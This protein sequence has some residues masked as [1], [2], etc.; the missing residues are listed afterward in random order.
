[1]AAAFARRGLHE[2]DRRTSGDWSALLLEAAGRR[3]ASS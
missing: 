3:R 2:H 1:V